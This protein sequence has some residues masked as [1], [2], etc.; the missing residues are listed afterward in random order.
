MTILPTAAKTVRVIVISSVRPEPTSAGQLILHRHLVN[1]PGIEMEVYGSEPVRLT[2]SALIRRIAG[3]LG[4]TPLRRFIEDFWA[5]WEGRWLDSMLPGSISKPEST[6]VLTVAHGDACM[7]ALRFAKTHK[8]PLVSLFHDWWPDIPKTHAFFHRKLDQSFRRLYNASSVA[9]CVSEG[10]R[11]ALGKHPDAR[12]IYPIPASTSGAKQDHR[13]DK[14]FR[15]HYFGNLQE[16]GPMLGEA[17]QALHGHERILLKVRGSNPV[18]EDGFKTRMRETGGWLDFESREKFDSW[19]DEAD[20]FLVPMV[21]EPAMR[22]R[23]ET[24]FPSK[25]VESSQLGKPLVIWGPEYCSAVRWGKD[26]GQALCVTDPDP[27]R[28]VSALEK[29]TGSPGNQERLSAAA[30]RA[31]QTDFDHNEIQSQFL[32][33]LQQSLANPARE[34]FHRDKENK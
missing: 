5:V 29:L 34:D 28:L 20:A 16:Y 12:V 14:P 7:A 18:W 13:A 1:H 22:R 21:F 11:E 23:M 6:I 17:L 24:S 9:V 33:A 19:L 31:A 4:T 25:L 3:R 32:D 26:T 27:A 10:M 30:R 2:L 15:V 8:L